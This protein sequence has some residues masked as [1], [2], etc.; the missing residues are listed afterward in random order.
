MKNVHNA[1]V[2]QSHYCLTMD[3]E[4]LLQTWTLESMDSPSASRACSSP[5]HWSI[6]DGNAAVAGYYNNM[7]EAA[8][9]VVAAA[10]Q[11]EAG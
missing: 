10:T 3:Y 2:T 6:V 11:Q 4:I 7:A 8:A 5:T 1:L 9:A